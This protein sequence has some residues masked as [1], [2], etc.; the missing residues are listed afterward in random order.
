MEE[1]R[2]AVHETV[3]SPAVHSNSQGKSHLSAEN[4]LRNQGD[5]AF[6]RQTTCR[7]PI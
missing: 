7:P 2:Q 3:I 4:L 6:S 5:R 1:F